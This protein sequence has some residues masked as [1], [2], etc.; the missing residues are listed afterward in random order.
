MFLF[1]YL[2]LTGESLRGILIGHLH[3]YGK[4]CNVY[5]YACTQWLFVKSSIIKIV[6]IVMEVVYHLHCTWWRELFSDA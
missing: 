1:V 5:D 6:T 3:Q 4:V 2:R